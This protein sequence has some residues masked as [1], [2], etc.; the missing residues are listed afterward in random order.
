MVYIKYLADRI[1]SKNFQK[2]KNQVFHQDQVGLG[3]RI[4]QKFYL[5]IRVYTYMVWCKSKAGTEFVFLLELVDLHTQYSI[6]WVCLQLFPVLNKNIGKINKHMEQ[7]KKDHEQSINTIE[8]SMSTLNKSIKTLKTSRNT[9]GKINKSIE[10]IHLTGT[11]KPKIGIKQIDFRTKNI[12]RF[13][14]VLVCLVCVF[15]MF[16]M[17]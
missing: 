3:D 7:I 5:W 14:L 8:K 15:N 10:K 13:F 6:C 9:I 12:F 16:K 11:F 2:G 4:F 17:I 1:L